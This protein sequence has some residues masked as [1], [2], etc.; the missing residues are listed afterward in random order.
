MEA[1]L[2]TLMRLQR[3]KAQK[4]FDRWSKFLCKS[5]VGWPGIMRSLVR[6]NYFRAPASTKYHLSIPSGLLIHSVG[7]TLQMLDFAKESSY[8]FPKWK[9]LVS[10]LLHDVGKCG[11]LNYENQDLHPRYE[12]LAYDPAKLPARYKYLPVF[13]SF[14]LR[15]LSALYAAKWGLPWDIVQAILVHDGMFVQANR[16]YS[17]KMCPLALLT[18][19]ADTFIGQ[20]E[21][22]QDFTHQRSLRVKDRRQSKS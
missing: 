5:P 4:Q 15:D 7:V 1:I 10:G 18:M 12:E 11:L 16:E 17:H 2:P 3:I 20:L 19:S 13:P 9:I 8:K 14:E 21:E 22:T 6:M